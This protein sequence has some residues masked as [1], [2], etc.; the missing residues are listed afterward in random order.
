MTI[1]LSKAQINAIRV[2]L[3]KVGLSVV[4]KRQ[5]KPLDWITERENA[6]RAVSFKSQS[7]FWK[8]QQL[9]LLKLRRQIS[10]EYEAFITR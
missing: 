3:A 7:A 8:T 5:A 1:Q 4:I 6:V 2:E 10:P 9:R